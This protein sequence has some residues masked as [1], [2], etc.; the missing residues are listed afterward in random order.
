MRMS[1]RRDS[2]VGVRRNST[3]QE[4]ADAAREDLPEMEM[5]EIPVTTM[6]IVKVSMPTAGMVTA[7]PMRTMILRVSVQFR[8]GDA[9]WSPLSAIPIFLIS[10]KCPAMLMKNAGSV[11]G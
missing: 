7:G 8:P 1:V 11:A 10:M 9:T 3:G 6:R 4:S 5:R 2:T